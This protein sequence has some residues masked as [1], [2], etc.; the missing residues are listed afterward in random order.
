MHMV[1]L[2]VESAYRPGVG[3]T[4]PAKLLFDK[5]GDLPGQNTFAVLG[6]PDKLIGAYVVDVFGVLCLHLRQYNRC[7]NLQDRRRRAALPYLKDRGMRWPHLKYLPHL[8]LVPHII[9]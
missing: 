6:T 3:F 8:R 1:F 5:R 4:N 7:S 9:L 2:H